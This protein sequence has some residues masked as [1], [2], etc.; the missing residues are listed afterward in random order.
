MQMF[1]EVETETSE[2]LVDLQSPECEQGRGEGQGGPH[3]RPR[4]SGWAAA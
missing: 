1:V 3:K 2:Q 4:L